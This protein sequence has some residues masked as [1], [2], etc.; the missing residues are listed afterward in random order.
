[1]VKVKNR[2]SKGFLSIAASL[3]GGIPAIG[4]V[5]NATEKVKQVIKQTAQ[6]AKKPVK[7]TVNKKKKLT[8]RLKKGAKKKGKKKKGK[9]KLGKVFTQ[10]RK[11]KNNLSPKQQLKKLK[12]N[13]EKAILAGK[14]VK[15]KVKSV[16]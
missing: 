7:K 15:Q 12:K 8:A 5:S 14:A 4:N 2:K 9:K 10:A 11:L 16:V 13:I 3:L 6:S 1:M